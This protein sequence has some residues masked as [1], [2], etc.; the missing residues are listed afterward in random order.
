MCTQQDSSSRSLSYWTKQ[1]HLL[2]LLLISQGRM[3]RSQWTSIPLQTLLV[4]SAWSG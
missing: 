1:Q 2:L 3:S 4:L